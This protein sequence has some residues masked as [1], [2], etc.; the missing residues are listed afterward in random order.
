MPGRRLV[1]VSALPEATWGATSVAPAAATSVLNDCTRCPWVGGKAPE[2]FAA[3]GTPG[4][5]EGSA[6]NQVAHPWALVWSG[7]CVVVRCALRPRPPPTCPR[8]TMEVGIVFGAVVVGKD[9]LFVRLIVKLVAV[10]GEAM[11]TVITT[12][13]HVGVVADVGFNAAHAAVEPVT[14]APQK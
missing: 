10:P 2:T 3:H 12:G 7:L 13:D 8:M 6:I 1:H 4:G 11:G 14:A 5:V 9:R